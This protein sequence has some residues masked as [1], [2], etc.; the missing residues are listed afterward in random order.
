M[1][2]GSPARAGAVGGALYMALFGAGTLPVLLTGGLLAG[3]LYRLGHDRRFQAVAGLLVVV[4][5]LSTLHFQGYNA[6]Q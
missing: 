4:L 2:I 1:L 5:G 6:T 3:R